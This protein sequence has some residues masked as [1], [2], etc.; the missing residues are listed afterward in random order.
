MEDANSSSGPERIAGESGPGIGAQWRIIGP[1]LIAAI[2][3]R[4]KLERLVNPI[5]QM[6]Y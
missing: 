5:I 6:Y 2:R 4:R 3:S 1:S